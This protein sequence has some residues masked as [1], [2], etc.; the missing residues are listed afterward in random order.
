[1]RKRI[2]GQKRRQYSDFGSNPFAFGVRRVGRMVAA[3]SAAKLRAEVG[4]LNL[5]ELLDLAP[6]FVAHGAGYVD[7]QFHDW[8]Y[9]VPPGKRRPSAAK[10][11]PY[12]LL[13]H[14]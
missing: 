11:A 1:M 13:W 2:L 10:A 4:A 8:H 9:E 3:A 6:G 7:F 14:D 12:R 5:I